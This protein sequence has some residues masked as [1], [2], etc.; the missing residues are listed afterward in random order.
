VAGST[1]DQNGRC[2]RRPALGR[3]RHQRQRPHQQLHHAE[4]AADQCHVESEGTP[5]DANYSF[6]T[7]NVIITDSDNANVLVL[8]RCA[9]FTAS[10]A[11]CNHAGWL[12]VLMLSVVPP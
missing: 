9:F 3:D 7:G 4:R 12:P 1:R 2:Q 10:R 6:N 5:G 11:D 8:E